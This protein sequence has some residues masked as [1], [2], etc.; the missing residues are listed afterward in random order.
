MS[1]S[2]VKEASV[3]L[4]PRNE[5]NHKFIPQSSLHKKK[6]NELNKQA[7]YAAVPQLIIT[8]RE[9]EKEY[10]VSPPKQWKEG[11]LTTK[12][13]HQNSNLEYGNTTPREFLNAASSLR[14]STVRENLVESG[15]G[16]MLIDVKILDTFEIKGNKLNLVNNMK[17]QRIIKLN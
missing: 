8:S 17:Q 15:T 7:S 16:T 11:S 13:M 9:Q 10:M 2:D 4:M 12:S 1:N 14:R 3:R 6:N 5:Q